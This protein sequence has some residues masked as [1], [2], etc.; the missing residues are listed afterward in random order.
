MNVLSSGCITA[1]SVS[2]RGFPGHSQLR[3]VVM[4]PQ[5]WV[6]EVESEEK[7]NFGWENK[8]YW[9]PHC[10]DNYTC[11]LTTFHK[12][13]SRGSLLDEEIELKKT[14]IDILQGL[15]EGQGE[16]SVER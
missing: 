15:L 3:G 9:K 2:L 6:V 5:I 13:L 1:Q 16:G 12:H 8:S 10:R 14:S 7:P 4:I 11:T